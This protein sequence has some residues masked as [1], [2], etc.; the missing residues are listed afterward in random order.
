MQ[1]LTIFFNRSRGLGFIVRT[2]FVFAFVSMCNLF[3]SKLIE[4][5]RGKKCVLQQ[6]FFSGKQEAFFFKEAQLPP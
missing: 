4:G 3:S 2:D 5:H 6:Y 1:G